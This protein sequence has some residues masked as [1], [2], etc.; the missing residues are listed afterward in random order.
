MNRETKRVNILSQ[1][2]RVSGKVKF[3]APDKGYGFIAPDDGSK[4]LF[5]H[6]SDLPSGVDSLITE[7]R[8][9]FVVADSDRKGK[10]DGKKAA[11]V[12]VI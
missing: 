5:V 10:G 11:K 12:Q 9:S 1:Q 4:D 3:F 8:V 7:Q 6:K 2:Q